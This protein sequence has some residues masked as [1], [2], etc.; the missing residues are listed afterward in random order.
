MNRLPFYYGWIIVGIA[1]L[2]MAISVSARTAFSLMMLPILDEFGWSRGLVAGAF[3]FGFML[4]AALSPVVGKLM[5]RYGPRLVIETGVVFLAGGMFLAQAIEKPWQLYL[6]LGLL[7]S[8]GVNLMSFT[9][10]SLYLPNWF[11]RRRAFATGIAFSGV[12]VGA[13]VLLPW[14]QSIIQQ[15]GWREACRFIAL[16]SI[17]ILVPL[18][19]FVRHR[20]EDIGAIADGD[21][22]LA[23]TDIPRATLRVVDEAWVAIDWTL[24]RTIRTARFWWIVGSYFC[25]TFA[26]YAVQVHQTKFLTEAGFS[27][28]LAAWAL[29]IV[30]VIAIPGQIGLGAL[31]DRIGREWVWTIACSGFAICYLA[32]IGLNYTPSLI[33][34]YIM[35]ISQGLL[36]Y[37]MT[38]V[39]AAIVAEIFQGLHFGAIFGTISVALLA[40]GAAGPWVSGVLYDITGSYQ[41]AFV[42]AFGC[43]VLSAIGIWIAAP[44]KV[45]ATPGW[46]RA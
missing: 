32:L 3:S 27:P 17:G 21:A 28:V 11:V 30:S 34:L 40:G 8:I 23:E 26:W 6:S 45:R 37:A 39:L 43:C 5:D 19:L 20:P 24:A 22:A 10:Q 14:L 44:R 46:R 35:I 9:V 16:M 31:S 41:P 29:G 4:S 13:I 42:L 7:V 2:T 1:F 38:S 12:G 15:D 33:L 36:G 18:N 25:A